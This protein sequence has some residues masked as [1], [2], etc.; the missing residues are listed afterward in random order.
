MN[1]NRVTSGLF[2]LLVVAVLI[3]LSVGVL[4]Q[5]EAAYKPNY[6]GYKR[7]PAERHSPA[8]PKALE[9]PSSVSLDDTIDGAD[10][11]ESTIRAVRIKKGDT[12][13]AVLVRAGSELREAYAAGR[14]LE[15]RYNMKRLPIGTELTTVFAN[16]PDRRY[17]A[18]VSLP[19][20]N[21]G[22]LVAERRR[23]LDVNP[24]FVSDIRAEPKTDILVSTRT[25]APS[26]LVTLRIRK[27]DTLAKALVRAGGGL[28]EAYLAAKEIGRHFNLRRVQIDQKV[29]VELGTG[30][31]GD[32]ALVAADLALKTGEFIIA[33]RAANGGF[34]AVRR[35]QGLN[36]SADGSDG[37]GVEEP[38]WT[39]QSATGIVVAGSREVVRVRRGDSLR[40]VLRRSGIDGAEAEAAVRALSK[41]FDPRNLQIGQPVTMVFGTDFN[42]QHGLTALGISLSSTHHVVANRLPTGEF[43]VVRTRQP[44]TVMPSRTAMIEPDATE[45][46]NSTSISGITSAMEQRSLIAL[47]DENRKRMQI[48]PGDTLMDVLI[49][50]GCERPDAHQAI[51]AMRSVYDPREL[52]VG[53]TLTVAFNP[54]ETD[55]GRTGNLTSGF[56]G[57]SLALAPGRSVKVGR[58]DDAGFAA[59]MV[60]TPLTR[61]LIHASN[62]ISSSLYGAAI[63][64]ELPMPVLMDI[65]SVFSFD[66]DFQRE[67]QPGD[68]FA[69]LFERFSDE[70]GR[71]VRDGEVV[72]AQL[73]LSGRKLA[74]YRHTT[75]DGLT[76]YF[77][78]QGHSIQKS[79]MRTPING[80]R[81]SSGF[82]M[83]KHPIMGYNKMHRGVDFAAPS[84]T[85]IKAA[86]AGV[87]E[88]A[89]RNGG[90]GNYVRIRHD[91]SYATAYAHLSRFAK[92]V[93]R[94]Q[95]VN[96]G[97]VIGYVGST[98][99]STG[100]HLHYEVLRNGAQ[101]N[102]MSVKLPTGKKLT[103]SALETFARF[104]SEI[105]RRLA[106]LP[107]GRKL[108]ASRCQTTETVLC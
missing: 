74:V 41:G 57:L 32:R 38:K 9:L 21:G 101:I 92:G 14:A 16:R 25:E 73:E 24:R 103:G 96:Q 69:V 62:E 85:P 66:V 7:K 10:T 94:G 68:N 76:D 104:R 13:I 108:A 31:D 107:P 36:V 99:R 106:A 26:E 95:R 97:Q 12:L 48:R 5:S 40:K 60:E 55:F 81:L 56:T 82:G 42:G 44:L 45:G 37:P 75:A 61:S 58:T 105:D 59:R 18:S 63:K 2:S 8:T 27:G 54:D 17:L 51:T 39:A 19:L 50:A 72:Y 98:G 84:G 86:G 83:R 79:L 1:F 35:D 23:Y 71:N 30:T 34:Q 80:A 47:D 29:T 33:R 6:L 87:V 91:G 28:T 52:Q 65:I 4:Y 3:I 102:P 93:R 67:I 70:T 46:E 89:G 78:A 100:P 43:Q 22:Y 90:Y 64:A 88:S 20:A 77:N 11:I 49:R 53:Q 15:L